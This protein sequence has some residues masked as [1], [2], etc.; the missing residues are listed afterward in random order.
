MAKVR[1]LPAEVILLQPLHSLRFS[2]TLKT[3]VNFFFSAPGYTGVPSICTK[4]KALDAFGCGE[5]VGEI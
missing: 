1:C 5:R 4:F 2:V 3:A